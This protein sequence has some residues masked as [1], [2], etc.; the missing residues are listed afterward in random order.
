MQ[1]AVRPRSALGEAG[2]IAEFVAIFIGG[3]LALAFLLPPS[4]MFPALIGVSLFGAALLTIT[5][6]FSWRELLGG[7][8]AVPARA[9]LAL[10]AVT[11]AV[12]AVLVHWLVPHMWLF[13]PTRLPDLWLTILV[14]YPL[15]SALPQE[16]IFRV[17]FFR[18]YGW[19]FADARAAMAAN[20]GVFALAHLMFWNW[21]AVVLTFAGGWIFAWAYLRGGG[22]WSAVV[23]HAVAGMIVFTLGLGTFF[24]HG[25]VPLR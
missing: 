16:V 19:L 17:L 4:A 21:P 5:A 22:F 24:Y 7:M 8:R 1:E 23:L 12:S 9:V 20:A 13:L 3:P 18:R 11:A 2:R 10:A 14:L 15:L 25:A 6:G